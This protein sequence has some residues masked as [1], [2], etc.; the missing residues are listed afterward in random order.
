MDFQF[1]NY[2]LQL[3]DFKTMEQG[4]KQQMGVNL[5]SI[6][7]NAGLTIVQMARK[8]AI[9]PSQYKKYARGIESIRADQGQ[10]LAINVGA[11]P[12]QLNYGT[13][14]SLDMQHRMMDN[15]RYRHWLGLLRSPTYDFLNLVSK[16]ESNPY[17]KTPKWQLYK[18]VEHELATEEIP[19]EVS[20]NFYRATAIAM[21]EFRGVCGISQNDMAELLQVSLSSYQRYESLKRQPRYSVIIAI[22]FFW[23]TRIDPLELLRLSK[24]FQVRSIQNQRLGYLKELFVLNNNQQLDLTQQF[25]EYR[26]QVRTVH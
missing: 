9:S 1:S 10:L 14:Y 23:A 12:H 5:E 15:R 22:R 24:V 20:Q 26:H 4:L 16:I 8:L 13:V 6:R 18:L 17:L 7:R 3:H 2:Q 25:E 11:F 19:K 21:K